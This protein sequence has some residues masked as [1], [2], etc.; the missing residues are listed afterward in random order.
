MKAKIFTLLTFVFCLIASSS[1]SQTVSG[2]QNEGANWYFGAYAGLTWT[3]MQT[4]DN[5]TPLMDGALTTNEGVATISDPF[6]VL[7]FYTDGQ[8]VWAAD[9]TVWPNTTN[10]SI[11]GAL[12]GNASSTQS[13]VIVP[14]PGDANTYYVFAVDNNIGAD[15]FTYSR[16]DMTLNSGLGDIDPAEK[17]ISLQTPSCE[18]CAAVVHANGTDI[19]VLSHQWSSDA[20]YAYIVTSTGVDYTNPVITNIGAM[21]SGS[22]GVTRGYMKASPGGGKIAVGIEGLN[23]YELFDFDA[24]TGVLSNVVSFT[25]PPPTSPGIVFEDC[26]GVE[27]S[28]D[29]H[30]LYGSERWGYDIH[31]WDITAA[32][33]ADI[34]ASHTVVGT[35]STANGGALQL[36]PDLKIYIARNS[37][38]YLSCITEPLN[39]GL[40]S[41]FVEEQVILGPDLASAKTSREGLPT[42]IATFFNVAEFEFVTS[43]DTDTTFFTIPNAQQMDN[44]YWNFNYPSVD[45]IYLLEDTAAIQPFIYPV[46][47]VYTVELVT[48]RNGD[49]DTVYQ[50]VY[51]SSFPIV[52]LGPDLVLCEDETVFY[53]LS[54]NDPLALDGSCDYFW[55]ADLGIV[56]NY[57]SS[58]SFLIDK[59]GIYTVTV[60]TDS[61]CGAKTDSI[62]IVYNNLVASL[63]VDVTSGLCQ[64]DTYTLDAEYVN[65]DYG[66]TY[67]QWNTNQISPSINVTS[68]G[69]YSVTLS[70]G[71]CVDV[72]SIEVF[73]D[74]PLY[75]ALDPEIDLCAGSLITLH[76]G[77]VGA[78]YAW[79]TG[80]FSSTIDVDIPGTYS[81]SITNACGTLVDEIVVNPLDVPSFDLGADITICE[82]LPEV[83]NAFVDGATYLWSTGS[84]LPQLAVMTAGNYTVTVTNQ[85]GSSYD[86]INVFGDLPLNNI[87]LGP[88][89]AVCT[90]FILDVGYP[91]ME[92]YW[93]TNATTQTIEIT[94][95]DDYSVDVTNAC[96]TYTDFIHIDVI[97]LDVNLGPDV[98]ICPGDVA[99]LDAGNIGAAFNWSN[100]GITQTTEVNAAGEY[101]VMVTNEC[102]TKSDTVIVSIFDITL[103]LGQDIAACD[104][105]VVILDAAHPGSDYTWSTG[106]STQTIEVDVAGTYSVSL[107]HNC[108]TIDDEVEVTFN[109]LPIVD[110]GTDTVFIGENSTAILSPGITGIAYLWSTGETT[111]TIEVG[112]EDIYSVTVTDDNGCE[113]VGEVVLSI[114]WGVTQVDGSNTVL[115]Y[116]N[117]TRDMLNISV[118]NIVVDKIVV[119]NSIGKL[120]GIY[121][122]NGNTISIQTS[123]MPEG[124]YFVKVLSKS[125]EYIIKPFSI[126]R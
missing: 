77:N 12:L 15:G 49:Y 58:A 110:F 92:Y 45:P 16:A 67:Y 111:E 25:I 70:L 18:K 126:V 14:K 68:S 5:P 115:L 53:D 100:G 98:V 123:N 117:P 50:D 1:Y 32:S 62:T 83:V 107:V 116:P 93:S 44:A 42:F 55:E 72:D 102:E 112:A 76:A 97:E 27:F 3:T 51:V 124:V 8:T 35:L 94:S 82:G 57:D 121:D 28:V 109:P 7:L 30:Y 41:G 122:H 10:T 105:D 73:F 40:A 11:G 31:Q 20:F 63:G 19:W 4:N 36:A 118:N 52:D 37:K 78:S 43:C 119:Y 23:I 33:G 26:Y 106:E 61:I 13:G 22:S 91:D 6:G 46:G 120:L 95:T 47:G 65:T 9:H 84:V 89:T 66:L 2:Y 74:A 59:P 75:E 114:T 21:N 104:G 101:T 56:T 48:E 71:A 80:V 103:D 64:G 96:G 17:N 39:G 60:M 86:A 125:G 29:E 81:V 24:A 87:N 79:S 34:I 99:T 90:G 108:G 113:G 85:C 54:F 38:K 69:T 88:D